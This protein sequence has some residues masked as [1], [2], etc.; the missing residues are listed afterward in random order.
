MA[1]LKFGCDIPSACAIFSC[2]TELFAISAAI[3]EI[4]ISFVDHV[5][6]YADERLVL[7]FKNGKE[8]TISL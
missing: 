3:F 8:V 5:T 7:T 2:V 6:V 4:R 1:W